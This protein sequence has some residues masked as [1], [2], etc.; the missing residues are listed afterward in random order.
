MSATSRP[1]SRSVCVVAVL[2]ITSAVACSKPV[3]VASETLDA[4]ALEHF[5]TFSVTAPTPIASRVAAEVTND[6]NRAAGVVMD[7]DPML[8]TSLVGRAMSEELATAFARRG[9]QRTDTNPNFYVAYYAGTGKVVDTRAAQSQYH[10]NGQ[11][12]ST[13]TYEY[14]AGTIVVD[15]V[16]ARSDSLVWRGTGLAEIPNDPDDY[17]RMIRATIDQV[18]AQFPAKR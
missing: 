1:V 10:V 13:K 16:D 2:V 12:L 14:P 6:S 4:K 8:A 15:V 11:Q 7:M 3:R 17:S 9:Y 5:A 18:V